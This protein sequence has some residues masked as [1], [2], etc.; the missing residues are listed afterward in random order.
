MNL[1]EQMRKALANNGYMPCKLDT[2]SMRAA[3]RWRSAWES[4]SQ[5]YME[6]STTTISDVSKNTRKKRHLARL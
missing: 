3:F 2:R 6:C 4:V 1:V 5:F